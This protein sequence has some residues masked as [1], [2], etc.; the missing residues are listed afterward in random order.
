[1][2]QYRLNAYDADVWINEFRG[3]SPYPDVINADM[4]YAAEA[5]NAETKDG[6]LQPF[7]PLIKYAWTDATHWGVLD[8]KQG[9]NHDDKYISRKYLHDPTSFN[10]YDKE[11]F[12]D[13]NVAEAGECQRQPGEPGL[14]G[15]EII[16]R[17][18]RIYACNVNKEYA[19]NWTSDLVLHVISLNNHVYVNRRGSNWQQIYYQDEDQ[20]NVYDFRSDEW[21]IVSCVDTVPDLTDPSEDAPVQCVFMSNEDDGMYRIRLDNMVCEKID[22]PVNFT[23]IEYYAERLWGC[24]YID[25]SDSIFYSTPYKPSDFDQNE[26]IPED[27]GGE[28]VLPNFD[29]DDFH[30]VKRMGDHLYAFKRNRIYRLS[31]TDPASWVLQEQFGVGTKFMRSLCVYEEKM[32]MVTE[33]GLAVYDGAVVAPILRDLTNQFWKE[34]FKKNMRD[35]NAMIDERQPG[36]CANIIDGKYCVAYRRKATVDAEDMTNNELLVYDLHT[37]NVM[38]YRDIMIDDFAKGTP[39]ILTHGMH[40]EEGTTNHIIDMIPRML[41]LDGSWELGKTNGLAMKWVSPWVDFGY[42]TVQKGGFDMYILPEVQSTAVTLK[43]SIQ[44]EKKTKTKSYTV[45]PLTSAEI[46]AGKKHKQK[47]LHFGGSGRRFRLIIE[48]AAGNTAPWRLVGGIHMIAETD[49]D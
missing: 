21:S 7:S 1:M 28:I 17:T 24:S 10:Q 45:Q 9:T 6:A 22:T 40:I 12:E 36:I 11:A 46:A 31:G 29:G 4:R 20:Q 5:D 16:P 49:A 27:G 48:T 26:D 43:F 2:A 41:W 25:R 23:W 8:A 37:G 32:Y 15:E 34:V 35:T 38:I 14:P 3:L 13:F 44:T 30:G 19:G 47:K 33:D 18:G 42:R 39:I